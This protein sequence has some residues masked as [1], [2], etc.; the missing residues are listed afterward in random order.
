ML[1][2]TPIERILMTRNVILRGE[3][4]LSCRAVKPPKSEP[5]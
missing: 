4:S 3:A 1:D 5:F 2:Y